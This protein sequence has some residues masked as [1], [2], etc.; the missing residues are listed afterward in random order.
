MAFNLRSL[1]LNPVNGVPHEE[2]EVVDEA[3]GD[4]GHVIV[5]APTAGDYAAW[6]L[7][8]REDAGITEADDEAAADRK[9]R[10]ADLS[11]STAQLV[12]RVMYE[13]TGTGAKTRIDR[14]YA[15]SDVAE[16]AT[17]LGPIHALVMEKALSLSGIATVDEAK[18]ASPE[19]PTSGS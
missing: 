18:N 3:T 5:R 16:L 1:L 10:Q 4:K 12:V 17:K 6:R 14:V 13:R 7:A 9:V 19:S 11:R 2:I 8:I 15:D